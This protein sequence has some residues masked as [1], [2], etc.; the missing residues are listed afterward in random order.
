[1]TDDISLSVCRDVRRAPL[2]GHTSASDGAGGSGVRALREQVIGQGQHRQQCRFCKFAF[3]NWDGFEL[4][5]LDGDHGNTAKEN[6]TPICLLCHLPF[7]LD[8][9]AKRWPGQGGGEVG[10]IIRCPELSQPE[11]NLTLYALFFSASQARLRNDDDASRRAWSVYHRLQARGEAT[12]QEAGRTV[13]PGLSK[14]HVVVRLL[15]D[16]S[17]ARYRTR[18]V[19][20]EGLR[21][22]PPYEPMIDLAA[23]WAKD[24]AAFSKLDVVSWPTLV[25]SAA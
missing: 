13:R 22:L 2:P 24:G 21:Y 6:V 14:V 19:W 20:L 4:H 8:L 10:R 1:M 25:G 16:A 17:E 23:Q 15:Q 18:D 11:L 9:V 12:E 3:G 5:H 7:H